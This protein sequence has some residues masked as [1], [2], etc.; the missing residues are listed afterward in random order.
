MML[1][2]FNWWYQVRVL[3]IQLSKNIQIESIWLVLPNK[4]A[5]PIIIKNMLCDLLKEYIQ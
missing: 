5:S 2:Q 3:D 1:F 4:G